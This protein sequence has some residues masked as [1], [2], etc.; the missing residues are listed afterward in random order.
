MKIIT[1]RRQNAGCASPASLILFLLLGIL[2]GGCVD[3]VLSRLPRSLDRSKNETDCEQ[4]AAFFENENNVVARLITT[5]PESGTT[6]PISKTICDA[7]CCGHEVEDHLRHKA[8]RDFHNLIHHHSRS[9]Q[10]LLAT[11]ADAL[12]DDRIHV[13]EKVHRLL[14]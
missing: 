9:L 3:A 13:G 4:V 11:T 1:V 2:F 6:S 14:S 10:G 5:R 7:P 12:R 8:G